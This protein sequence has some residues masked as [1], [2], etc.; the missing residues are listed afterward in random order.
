MLVVYELEEIMLSF[1]S[2]MSNLRERIRPHA[3]KIVKDLGQSFNTF[4]DKSI[5]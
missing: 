1:Q 4:Y 2:F 5:S 3:V